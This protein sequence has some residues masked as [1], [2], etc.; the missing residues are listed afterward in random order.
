MSRPEIRDRSATTSGSPEN[1]SRY[2]AL[3]RVIA[4]VLV[5]LPVVGAI[6]I[7]IRFLIAL[8]L[9][10]AALGLLVRLLAWPYVIRSVAVALAVW[11]MLTAASLPDNVPP[12]TPFWLLGI[13][14][15]CLIIFLAFVLLVSRPARDQAR[16]LWRNIGESGSETMETL[17]AK[18]IPLI[19]T[20]TARETDAGPE[21]TVTW[22][23]FA[24][25][26][27]V[28]RHGLVFFVPF[29]AGFAFILSFLAGDKYRATYEILLVVG[30]A[31]SIVSV[32]IWIRRANHERARYAA[33]SVVFRPDG[34]IAMN[35]PPS[36]NPNLESDGMSFA[37]ENGLKRLVSIEYGR[38]AEWYPLK[39]GYVHDPGDW[40]DV[41]M[42][43]DADHR[44]SV[45]RSV[46]SREHAHQVT[47]QLNALK[48]RLA[49][50]QPRRPQ[51]GRIID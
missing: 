26:Q 37:V 3:A 22:T 7:N 34:S 9:C 49:S 46:G 38:T 16:A 50:A 11:P 29:F 17:E 27:F 41:F 8:P 44:I 40:Y 24:Q 15:V 20:T 13:S 43:F 4:I 51:A 12:S 31:L 48:A 32:G 5:V 6:A 25:L 35:N 28:D 19:A 30:I 2:T 45:G 10:I 14:A 42:M 18:G 39:K 1:R 47:G 33:R 36:S 21:F 23:D